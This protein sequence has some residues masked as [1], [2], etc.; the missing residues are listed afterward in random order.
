VSAQEVVIGGWSDKEKQ[1]KPYLRVANDGT[2]TVTGNLVVNGQLQ[3]PV[4]SPVV[5]SPEARAMAT[6]AAFN[7][8]ANAP[9]L[10]RAGADAQAAGKAP[11]GRQLMLQ[12]AV[13]L[14]AKNDELHQAFADLLK[15]NLAFELRRDLVITLGETLFD[16]ATLGRDIGNLL[17][18][19]P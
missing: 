11:D 19:L 15:Q 12:Q 13:M 1:F 5:L 10:V 3:A 6:S 8:I 7:L 9:N 17:K 18:R 16:N 14:L 2:V 4:Q